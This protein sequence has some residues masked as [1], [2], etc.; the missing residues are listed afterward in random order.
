MADQIKQFKT[1]NVPSQDLNRVQDNI[2]EVFKSIKKRIDAIDLTVASTVGPAGPAGA[3]GPAGSQGPAGA[4]GTYPTV[5]STDQAI[6]RFSGSQGQPQNSTVILDSVGNVETIK[7]ATFGST[8]QYQAYTTGS[9]T[10]DWTSNQKQRV[11]LSGSCSSVSFTDPKGIGNFMLHV[12]NAGAYTLSGWPSQVKWPGGS[13]PVITSGAGKN[14][15]I[16]FYWDGTRYFGNF[17]QDYS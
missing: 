3:Q 15:L 2:N 6:M 12:A 7:T 5:A 14:D 9:L 8:P 13:A 10:I 16:S 17:A 4:D 11:D 1:L